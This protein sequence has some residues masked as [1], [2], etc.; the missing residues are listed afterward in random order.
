MKVNV[1]IKKV[2]LLVHLCIQT[3]VHTDNYRRFGEKNMWFGSQR[4]AEVKPTTKEGFSFLISLL[5][6]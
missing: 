2:Y 6:D 4:S 5:S 1:L 3:S